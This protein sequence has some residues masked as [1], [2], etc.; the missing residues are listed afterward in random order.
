MV[1]AT[2]NSPVFK[3]S[4][5]VA[6]KIKDA[7]VDQFRERT[8][9][10]PSVDVQA[11]DVRIQIHIH[12]TDCTFSL[13]SSGGSLHRRGYRLEGGVAPL[14]EVLAAGLVLL[15]GWQGNQAFVDPMCGSGTILSEAYGIATGTPAGLWRKEYGFMRWPGY[16]RS[17]FDK[18]KRECL[19][20][21]RK[22][23]VPF[24]GFDQSEKALRVA[25]LN[26]DNQGISDKID[27]KVFEFSQLA[28][29]VKQATLIM[30]PP[31]G[32][33][34]TKDD[35]VGFYQ[36]IGNTLKRKWT[37]SEAWI[38]S[39][40]PDALKYVGLKPSRKINLFNGQLAC[41]FQRYELYDHS[42]KKRR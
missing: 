11:P 25:K 22:A 38:L 39:G 8:G 23:D 6:L 41:K 31:Y 24:F 7:I 3:H 9:L 18:I 17:L 10:R 19:D 27:L 5:F 26:F 33:R 14:N 29:P 1:S 2:V 35:L 16:Q 13:D 32:E 28:P 36:M 42:L 4:G 12:N 20:G 21:I 30:N 40:N 37:G 15:S 34:I